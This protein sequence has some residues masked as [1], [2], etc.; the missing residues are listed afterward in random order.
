M[1][2]NTLSAYS[3]PYAGLDRRFDGKVV[4]VAGTGSAFACAAVIAFARAG[5]LVGFCG[6][7]ERLG[8]S[9][10]GKIRA[11]GGA[12]T[13]RRTNL[14]DTD[15]VQVFV[16]SVAQR[17]GGLD[18]LVSIPTADGGHP[19]P[20]TPSRGDD[21]TTAELAGIT[22]SLQAALPHLM[23]R[24]GG[25]VVMTAVR[26]RIA[27]AVPIADSHGLIH[28]FVRTAAFEFAPV[29]VRVNALVTDA[30][31]DPARF[32]ALTLTLCAGDSGISSGTTVVLDA[33][34]D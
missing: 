32:A 4:I 18:V 30:G 7:H 31:T 22:P 16:D 25:A 29:N 13:Y 6:R 24:R 9:I 1:N 10:E 17:H 26:P 34:I 33:G 3:A 28:R 11:E 5:A 23:R 21:L 12:A 19:Q 27:D 8:R 14:G 20:G 15:Q 2:G